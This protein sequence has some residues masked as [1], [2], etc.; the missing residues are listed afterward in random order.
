MANSFDKDAYKFLPILSIGMVS[1]I[2]ALFNISDLIS[3]LGIAVFAIVTI[4]SF[5]RAKIDRLVEKR[6]SDKYIMGK[7]QEFDRKYKK[8]NIKDKAGL[9]FTVE[10]I[11]RLRFDIRERLQLFI[12]SIVSSI[13][14]VVFFLIFVDTL[15]LSILSVALLVIFIISL[16][17]AHKNVKKFWRMYWVLNIDGY[18]FDKL[19]ELYMSKFK[20]FSKIKNKD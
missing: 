4:L 19:A 13:A 11:S 12:V 10:A 7:E 17:Y 9:K 2:V 16:I 20:R 8:A 5:I 6:F 3:I 18:S 15:S 14:S 1:I